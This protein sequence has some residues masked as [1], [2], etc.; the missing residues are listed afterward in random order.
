MTGTKFDDIKDSLEIHIKKCEIKEMLSKEFLSAN[1]TFKYKEFIWEN[2]EP[3][4]SERAAASLKENLQRVIF[5]KDSKARH[6]KN[7][8]LFDEVGGFN[9]YDVHNNNQ[10]EFSCGGKI[11]R[12]KKLTT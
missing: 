1:L 4:D 5:D 7:F 12:G 9:C 6:K 11:Y 3:D 2:P 8:Q 10:L